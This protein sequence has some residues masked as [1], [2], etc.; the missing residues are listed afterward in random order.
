MSNHFWR[1]F[2]L[3]I[4]SVA[5]AESMRR[6]FAGR[7]DSS[8]LATPLGCEEAV[9]NL[10]WQWANGKNDFFADYRVVSMLEEFLDEER[11]SPDRY[12]SSF[13]KRHSTKRL[14][15][16]QSHNRG[17]RASY[18]RCFDAL[19]KSKRAFWEMV[20]G[21]SDRNADFSEAEININ[22]QRG[23]NPGSLRDAR[24]ALTGSVSNFYPQLSAMYH[25]LWGQ[26]H[27]AAVMNLYR[28][29]FAADRERLFLLVRGI[30]SIIQPEPLPQRPFWENV[31]PGTRLV[32]TAFFPSMRSSAEAIVIRHDGSEQSM[33]GGIGSDKGTHSW[34]WINN[35]EAPVAIRLVAHTDDGR[36]IPCT[37][38][39]ARNQAAIW[40]FG[41]TK[42]RVHKLVIGPGPI[43][44][45]MDL[46][47]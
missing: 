32:F 47:R 38:H 8:I 35:T 20:V 4:F 9:T 18:L 22:W 7:R 37:A 26:R 46:E 1:G 19:Q 2:G 44:T 11:R 30:S 3:G 43:G 28:S 36:S 13:H 17:A 24:E 27:N 29:C 14:L 34:E 42:G 31:L 25:L 12:E 23:A 41:A 16:G 39:S 10:V 40:E 21:A 45:R 15:A 33:G 5:V 6:R